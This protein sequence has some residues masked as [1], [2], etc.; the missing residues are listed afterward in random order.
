MFFHQTDDSASQEGSYF[1]SVRNPDYVDYRAEATQHYRQRHEA[2]Q[3]AAAA[4][5]QGLKDL[6]SFYS[7][8]VGA[9]WGSW[10]L[11][12]TYNDNYSLF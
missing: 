1:Q 6:A 7:Q 10:I 4:Y 11:N 5:K 8:Q 2:F 12:Q 9:A 3:K